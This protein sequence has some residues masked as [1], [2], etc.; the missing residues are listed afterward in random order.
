MYQFPNEVGM[1]WIR[2]EQNE[3][4]YEVIII[5]GQKRKIIALPDYGEI[6]IVC[7]D[8]RVKFVEKTVKEQL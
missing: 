3:R 6:K 7:H 1:E 8:G 5:E 2:M 4:K